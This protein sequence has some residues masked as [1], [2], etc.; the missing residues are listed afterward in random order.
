MLA[1]TQHCLN[2]CL[3][4]RVPLEAVIINRLQ[5]LPQPRQGDWLRNLLVTGFS[6][7]CQA[8]KSQ[9][10][11]RIPQGVFEH[12][13][14]SPSLRTPTP[15]GEAQHS[16]LATPTEHNDRLSGETLSVVRSANAAKPF[17]HLKSI[18]GT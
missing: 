14:R 9:A 5:R 3:D 4:T 13:Y 12:P 8:L 10:E 15:G 7:E 1:A 17:A 11:V 16:G 2:V 18:I 6:T